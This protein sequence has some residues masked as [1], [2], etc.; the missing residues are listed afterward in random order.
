MRGKFLKKVFALAASACMLACSLSVGVQAQENEPVKYVALGDSISSGYGVSAEQAFPSLVAASCGL[1]LKNDAV[2][3]AKSADMLAALTTNSEVMADVAAADVITITI[4]GNDLMGALY[5]YI[6]EKL[7]PGIPVTE[8]QIKNMLANADLDTLKKVADNIDGFLTSQAALTAM[9]GLSNNLTKSIMAIRAANENAMIIV[10]N[11]YNPYSYLASKYGTMVS[12]IKT[13]SAV[14]ESGVMTLNGSLSQIESQPGCFV[15]DVKS[16]FDATVANGENPCN[17]DAEVTMYPEFK[18]SLNLDFHPNAN[19]HALIAQGV[20]AEINAVKAVSEALE[21]QVAAIQG[22][23]VNSVEDSSVNTAEAAQA[24]AEA[25]IKPVLAEGVTATVQISDFQAA[26]AGTEENQAGTDGSF[27]AVVSLSYNG[28]DLENAA[29]LEVQIKATAY[30]A[31]AKDPEEDQNTEEDN[32]QATEKPQ[33]SPTAD[34][35]KDKTEKAEKAEEK[36]PKTGDASDMMPY[37]LL[38]LAAGAAVV[39]VSRKKS[40]KR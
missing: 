12:Q 3:G 1:E 4:G 2:E 7:M 36:S 22:A 20:A 25:L 28:Y 30:T 26:L 27:K 8:D 32:N 29:V 10:V 15:V 39:V 35:D 37:V 40:E 17:A 19:G 21:K 18:V 34:K 31:P 16:V 24:W 33:Q 13:I 6:G 9:S 11:Q 14:F 38:M 5:S 23:A